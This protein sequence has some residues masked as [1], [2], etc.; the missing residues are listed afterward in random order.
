MIFDLP[1]D[2]AAT[3]R[4]PSVAN[5]HAAADVDILRVERAALNLNLSAGFDVRARKR[6]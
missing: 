1:G 5:K 3:H 4:D 6:S 2:G